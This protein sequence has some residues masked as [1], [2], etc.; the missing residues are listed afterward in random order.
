MRKDL[1]E[2]VKARKIETEKL[3]F[4]WVQKDSNLQPVGY[5]PTSLTV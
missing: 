4:W 5:E 1:P 3:A 2:G